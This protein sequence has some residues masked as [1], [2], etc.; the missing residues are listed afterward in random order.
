MKNPS[1]V[2]GYNNNVRHNGRVYHI[3]TEDSGVRH[4]HI[5]THLFADGGR[6]V[7]SKKTSYAAHLSEENLSDLVKEMMRTQHKDMFV[8]LR[9]G[10]YDEDASPL[11]TNPTGTAISSTEPSEPPGLAPA[12]IPPEQ[13]TYQA[14][15][16]LDFE[17]TNP[18]RENSGAFQHMT[19]DE[20]ILQFIAEDMNE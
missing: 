16:L 5:I 8:S 19:L 10:V 2:T 14:S 4:P 17:D 11:T 7:A 15:S 12:S 1:P 9:N 13:P 6:V 20:V 18:M 3:Q